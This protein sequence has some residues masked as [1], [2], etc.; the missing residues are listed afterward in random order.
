MH[1]AEEQ[2]NPLLQAEGP[3][4]SAIQLLPLQLSRPAHAPVPRQVMRFVPALVE[5]PLMHD[6]SPMQT[7]SHM[8]PEH[9]VTP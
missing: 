5:A 9:I 4:Q 8:L 1:V 6:I 7:T 3:V 2:Q